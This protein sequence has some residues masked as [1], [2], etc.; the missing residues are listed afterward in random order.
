MLLARVEDLLEHYFDA[1][2]ISDESEIALLFKLYDTVTTQ[3]STLSAMIF[4]AEQIGTHGAAM[5]DQVRDV[6]AERRETRTITQNHRSRMERVSPM[7][8]PELWFETLL[9][10]QRQEVKN[11]E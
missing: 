6:C 9:A 7:P 1:V 3:R 2:R 8:T 11:G 4:S 10:K 5:V